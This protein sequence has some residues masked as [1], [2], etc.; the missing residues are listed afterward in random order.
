[1]RR[2][3]GVT[4]LKKFLVDTL[5]LDCE[6]V[7]TKLEEFVQSS[8]KSFG[9]DGVILGLSGG[10]DSSVAAYLCV[11]ALGKEGVHALIMPERDSLKKNIDNAVSLAKTLRIDYEVVDLKPIL[12]KMGVYSVI[13]DHIAKDEKLLEKIF[14]EVRRSSTFDS[15]QVGVPLVLNRPSYIL[16]FAVPKL[17]LRSTMLQFHAYLKNLLVV[18]TT[19]RS[20]YLVGQYEEHGDGACDIRLFQNLYKTQI[21]QLAKYLGV[22]KK[23]VETPSTP[24]LLMGSLITDEFL[25]GMSFEQLDSILYCIEQGMSAPDTAKKLNISENTVKEVELAIATAETRRNLPLIAPIK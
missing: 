1:M 14:R 21:R 25:I 10:I 4:S 12:E 18:G 23:I 22:P 20:E 17:R 7:T 11:R 24:D 2:F 15:H 19:N 6:A 13:P 9:K 5:R 16:A 8:V 3:S